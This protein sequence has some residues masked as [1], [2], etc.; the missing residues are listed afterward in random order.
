M[1]VQLFCIHCVFSN[2]RNSLDLHLMVVKLPDEDLNEKS[3]LGTSQ[4]AVK[5][6]TVTH[7]SEIAPL[8]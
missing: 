7:R 5:A 1:S 6:L 8:S 2:V 4:D 3:K